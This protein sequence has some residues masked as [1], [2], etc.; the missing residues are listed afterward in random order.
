MNAADE[1]GLSLD[2][3]RIQVLE[4]LKRC[5][6]ARRARDLLVEVDLSLEASDLSKGA[7]RAFWEG[8]YTD[9]DILTEESTFLLSQDEITLRTVVSAARA[10]I[11]EFLDAISDSESGI[12]R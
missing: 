10:D 1:T 9:L 7:Q 3:Y 12:A 6:D 8:L 11:A 5:P 4:K 2:A